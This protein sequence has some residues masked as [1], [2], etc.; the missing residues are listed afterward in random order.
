MNDFLKHLT[1]QYKKQTIRYLLFA[2]FISF[3]CS[4]KN[5]DINAQGYSSTNEVNVIDFGAIGN[6]IGDDTEAF[7]SAIESLTTTTADDSRGGVVHV[8]IGRYRITSTITV[9][10]NTWLRGASESYSTRLS[11]KTCSVLDGSSFPGPVVRL[12]RTNTVPEGL[13]HRGGIERLGFVASDIAIEIGDS[14]QVDQLHG[15]WNVSL[16]N[17]T[18]KN[19]DIGILA[20]HTQEALIERCFFQNCNRPIVYPTVIASSRII[21]NTFDTGSATGE[22]IGIEMRVGSQGGSA[23]ASIEGNYFLGFGKALLLNEVDG[24]A[25]Y[26]N[27]FEGIG[28]IELHNSIG[29]WFAGN[30]WINWKRSA[31]H[32]IDSKANHIVGNHYR[33][34][35]GSATAAI[36]G[37][38]SSSNRIVRPIII[39]S[40]GVPE[41]FGDIE[42]NNKII[43]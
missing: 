23:G 27:Q 17:L 12:L 16:R 26:A 1:S 5:T 36:I 40:Q 30:T 35:N 32:L 18:I 29:C 6:G 19:S 42:P 7:L 13:F 25:V 39:N 33:S 34:P 10:P 43:E 41:F 21:R 20:S 14:D 24:I 3:G 37:T 11:D 22:T 4:H 9:P 31:I 8:P 38:N 2:I 28:A 15:A